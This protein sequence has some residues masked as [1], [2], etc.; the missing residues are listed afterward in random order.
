MFWLSQHAHITKRHVCID[1]RV[2]IHFERAQQILILNTIINKHILHLQWNEMNCNLIFTCEV[3]PFFPNWISWTYVIN[4]S[5]DYRCGY[6]C[7]NCS[8][9][10]EET[11]TNMWTQRTRRFVYLTAQCVDRQPKCNNNFLLK[12]SERILYSR[13]N[14]LLVFLNKILF[15]QSMYLNIKVPLTV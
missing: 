1:L 8:D 14:I 11:Y 3:M 13:Y 2:F 4:W 6:G 12:I 5:H 10:L 15:L 9:A 7:R